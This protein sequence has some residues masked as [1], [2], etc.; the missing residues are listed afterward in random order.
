LRR[1]TIAA[2]VILV[3]YVIATGII[4]SAVVKTYGSDSIAMYIAVIAVG[5]VGILLIATNKGLD[6]FL[7][8]LDEN[9]E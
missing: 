1:R 9:D 3:G 5:P 7:R 6:V 8:G 4:I 2:I